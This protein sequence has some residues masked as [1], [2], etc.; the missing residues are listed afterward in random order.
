MKH[1]GGESLSLWEGS[2]D[3]PDFPPV[4]ADETADVC[5]IGGGISGLS[6]AY[7]LVRAGRSVIVIDDGPIAGGETGRT[8]AHIATEMDDRYFE[9]ARIHGEQQA[10]LCADSLI[11]AIQFIEDVCAREAID[12]DFQRLPAYLFLAEGDKEKTLD[13]EQEAATNAGLLG[14]EK[15]AD[16]QLPG[17][18]AGPALYFPEQGQFHS[19]KYLTGLAQAILKGGGR[20]STGTHA[21]SVEEGIPLKV[22][23]SGGHTISASQVVVATNSPITDV[24]KVHTKQSAY[25]TYV[26]AAKIPNGSVERCLYWD[27]GDPYH[28]VRIHTIDG[29]DYL[30]V[31]GEDHRTGEADDM[32]DRYSKL[33]LWASQWFP[34]IQE[35]S[36]RWSGQVLEPA[37]G[38]GFIGKDPAYKDN[39]YIATGDSGMGITNGT[40][41]GML[42]SDLILGKENPWSEIYDPSRK[43]LGSVTEFAKE[44]INTAAQYARYAMPSEVENLDQ[45][46]PGEGAIIRKGT[47][48][49]AAYKSPDGSIMQCSAVCTHL[50]GIVRWNPGERTWDCPAHGSRFY[51]NGQVCNGPANDD[52]SPV[53]TKQ[54]RE[55]A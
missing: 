11:K 20:I 16:L 23:C 37:D 40:I 55:S 47:E 15:L 14:V 38:L 1:P 29:Q 50:K 31:G 35:V 27:T 19:V 7:E 25:R 41:A 2:Q 36:Y 12:C 52:L 13:D 4:A 33:E 46:K 26:I 51:P 17:G 32:A 3:L 48:L 28:Y 53:E 9:I 5:I 30:I 24:V 42:L 43:P 6:T 44:N 39:V 10:R 54:E 34:M 49:I 18:S 22:K 21:Q 8:T 45:I